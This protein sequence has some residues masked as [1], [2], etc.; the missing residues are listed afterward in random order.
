MLPET[1]PL[2]KHEPPRAV[3]LRLLR[4]VVSRAGVASFAGDM[5]MRPTRHGHAIT[6]NHSPTYNSWVSMRTRCFS[7]VYKDYRYY[8]GRG[9]T[10]CSRWMRFESFLEDMGERPEGTSIDRIDNEGSYSCGHCEQCVSNGLVANCRWATR[11]QQSQN[12]KQCVL[13]TFNGETMNIGQ[14]A[15]YLGV[16]RYTLRSRLL[17]TGGSI[18][19]AMTTPVGRYVRK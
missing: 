6:G 8:G 10:I 12:S 17:K 4:C 5:Q 16:N 9:I 18:E 11:S 19:S 3:R 2:T 15:R 13:I 1:T 14:W 7:K